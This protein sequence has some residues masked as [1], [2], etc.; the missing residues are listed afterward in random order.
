MKPYARLT[1]AMLFA[2][3]ASTAVAA[4]EQFVGSWALTLPGGDGAGWLGVESKDGK[5]IASV[6]WGNGSV[7]PADQV[8]VAN[9]TLSI[10]RTVVSGKDS[11][12]Q[13][14]S[15]RRSDDLLHLLTTRRMP[16]GVEGELIS[17]SGRRI[18]DLPP[19]PD[20]ARIQ[21]EA[22]IS[23]IAES[24]LNGWQ[25]THRYS[26]NGWSVKDG[27][28]SNR[29]DVK[30][31]KHHT[32]LLSMR[33]FGDFRLTAE[34]RTL[35]GSNS[36]IY[37]RGMYEIQIAETFGKKADSHN[38]GAL[39]SRITPTASAEKPIGEWQT[40]DI[41]LV[42]RHLTIVLN[43]KKVIDNQPVLGCTGGAL[44]S[45]DPGRGPIML[46]GNHTDIDFRNFVIY[47]VKK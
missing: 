8:S 23:L 13:R 22:P 41:T 46:Q 10:V 12:K 38:M 31:G 43:G 18:A 2:S 37:L 28:L 33:K 15:A 14:I 27:I 1:I 11:Y 6:L 42:D 39:Y 40:L 30:S 25:P 24:D 29:V 26:K 16:D 4:E 5:L 44:T 3:V 7:A 20:L 35:A 47:P 9:D 45:E 21:Y 34:V 36:G 32:N 19:R 17:F